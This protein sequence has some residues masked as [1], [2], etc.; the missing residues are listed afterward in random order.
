MRWTSTSVAPV[1]P[2]SSS[3]ARHASC[4]APAAIHVILDADAEPAESTCAVPGGASTTSS[5]PSSVR[6][7]WTIT[8]ET[9]WPTS[10]AAQC[11]SAEPLSSSRTRAAQ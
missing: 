8:F 1:R 10:A 5:M 2:R 3:A 11:T 4:T 7:V 9:P 6:A